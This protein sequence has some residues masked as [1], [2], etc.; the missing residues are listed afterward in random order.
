MKA[1]MTTTATIY[2]ALLV[3]APLGGVDAAAQEACDRPQ[4]LDRYR[5][6][7]RMS[8]DLRQT[9]PSLD[10]YRLL[11]DQDGIGDQAVD[12]LL[13]S[14]GFAQAARRF[15]AD[16]LWPGFDAAIADGPI[17][18]SPAANQ[19][20]MS[21]VLAIRAASRRQTW[22]GQAIVCGNFEQTDF[23]ADGRPIWVDTEIEGEPARVDGWVEV[24]A[25]W[26][27][28]VK[29]CAFDAMAHAAG[30][31]SAC[32]VRT[33]LFDPGCGCGPEL[34]HC[35]GPEV[36][37]QVAQS[38]IEQMYRAIDEHTTGDRPYSELLTTSGVWMSGPLYHWKAHL[39]K[40][41]GI[42]RTLN[43][44][45]PGD[46][47]LSQARP[48]T[49]DTWTRAERTGAHA[50][51]ATLAAYTLRFQT[52]RGRANRLRIAYTDQYFVPPSG[53]DIGECDP[54]SGDLTKRCTC[55]HCHQVLEPLAAHFAPVL[56]AGSSMLDTS[57]LSI[58]Q[59]ACDPTV[60]NENVPNFCSRFYVT[61][62]DADNPGT[63]YGW[64]Y[65]GGEDPLHQAIAAN[66][67]AGPGGWTQALIDSGQMHQSTV[68]H[69]WRW[70]MGR[71]PVMNPLASDNEIMLLA[72]LA[73]EFRQNDDF[74]AIVK[75]LV[76]LDTYRRVR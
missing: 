12:Q 23:D 76:Q 1:W 41:V 44:Q 37:R 36:V 5:L 50:G 48:Y 40:M 32:D 21:D 68:V 25:Y 38:V 72:E 29:I 59:P 14:D 17:I 69:L 67:E 53:A 34:R 39:A 20:A 31:D 55:R 73:A 7:R 63:L 30:V 6:L 16:L 49:D 47:P 65:A 28:T 52:N 42:N 74:R 11:D 61:D 54:S 22:R 3:A 45:S 60:G 70:L 64:Q 13:A 9:L 24:E 4:E 15:H 46:A 62:P 26:G 56:E 33:A 27:E 58:Y 10:E 8:L 35:Y 2:L 71:E 19:G 43:S 18:L 51:I 66:I 57:L 75:R